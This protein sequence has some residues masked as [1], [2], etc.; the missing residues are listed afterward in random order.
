MPQ[1]YAYVG[2]W[3]YQPGSAA[4]K[5]AL[6]LQAAMPKTTTP[7]DTLAQYAP[8]PKAGQ[9]PSNFPSYPTGV[10]GGTGGP[11]LVGAPGMAGQGAFGLV[12]QVP[13]PLASAREAI[14]GNVA[15]L[16]GITTLGTGT[17]TLNANLAQLPFQL[18]QPNYLT[19]LG[20]SAGN[21][22]SNL[23]G[24]IDP[25][26][27]EAIQ[28]GAA[29]RG[30]RIGMGPASPN[31]NTSWMKAL[32]ETAM[33]A[34]SLGQQ[35]LNAAIART[36]TGLPFNAAGFQVGEP[37]VQSARYGANVAAAAPDPYQTARANLDM[38]L[39]AIRAG[40]AGGLGGMGGMGG[41]GPRL[42]GGG[43][44]SPVSSGYPG[45][46]MPY[47]W[48]GPTA[49]GKSVQPFYRTEPTGTDS[50]TDMSW[51]DPWAG[52]PQPLSPSDAFDPYSLGGYGYG[53]Y[54]V[55]GETADYTDF[56]VYNPME[57][58]FAYSDYFGG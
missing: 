44:L 58:D 21:I 35:Q 29:E 34:E 36:P 17:A 55:T 11:N 57:E 20:L 37:E 39:E 41:M 15:N 42:G 49:P 48:M 38:L 25:G 30:A 50:M 10:A 54:P 28:Q 8:T 51:T 43:M 18:N 52:I 12:P 1:K 7:E 23:R 13:D 6:Q 3:A 2:G 31:F 4:Y 56:G 46:N 24:E 45:F 19:N 14:A 47:Y 22:T 27:W 40:Q 9:A 32:G 53:N 26:T 33:Q 5:R 16:P